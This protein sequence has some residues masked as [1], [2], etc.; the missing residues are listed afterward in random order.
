MCPGVWLP[1]SVGLQLALLWGREIWSPS[2]PGLGALGRYQLEA[3]KVVPRWQPF[4]VVLTVSLLVEAQFLCKLMRLRRE[5]GE[6]EMKP[7]SSNCPNKVSSTF[8]S[9]IRDPWLCP[10]D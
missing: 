4:E 3:W 10:R 7:G 2:R 6:W 9:C 8:L 1:C 5:Y